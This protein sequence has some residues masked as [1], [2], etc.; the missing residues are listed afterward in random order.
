M[1][2]TVS[3]SGSV[4]VP[5][6]PV[7][8]YVSVTVSCYGSCVFGSGSGCGGLCLLSSGWSVAASSSCS[9]GCVV[10]PVV[11]SRVFFSFGTTCVTVGLPFYV[12]TGDRP[13]SVLVPSRSCVSAGFLYPRSGPST[14]GGPA[15]VSSWSRFA[16]GV[17]SA[18]KGF[19][20]CLTTEGVLVT[21]V[22]A[23]SFLTGVVSRVDSSSLESGG[24]GDG[25]R[26]RGA[27]S[28]WFLTSGG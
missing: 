11:P 18:S 26:S 4:G 6:P 8:R 23:L 3:D 9:T 25:E 14:A 19:Q 1:S 12:P 5:V 13:V 28:L 24:V 20:S 15:T 17:G 27:A 2:G 21:V 10:S 7:G 22:P 16:V